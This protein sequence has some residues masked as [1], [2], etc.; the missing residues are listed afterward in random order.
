M[1][2]HRRKSMKMKPSRDKPCSSQKVR[3]RTNCAV[4]E[5]QS[6]PLS[7]KFIYMDV[8]HGKQADLMEEQLKKL[9]AKVE[10]F[11]SGEVNYVISASGPT[12]CKTS[13]RLNVWEEN[14]QSPSLTSPFNC[15]PSPSGCTDTKRVV[16][17]RGKA[18]AQI[19]CAK[20]QTSSVVANAEKLG[21]KVI[22]FDVATKWLEKELKKI[23]KEFKNEG[24]LKKVSERKPRCSKSEIKK[25]RKLLRD[26]YIKFEAVNKCHRPIK[27]EFP[28]LPKLNLLSPPGICPFG[29]AKLKVQHQYRP[30]KAAQENSHNARMDTVKTLD[31]NPTK[32]D[33]PRLMQSVSLVPELVGVPIVTAGDVKCNL[34]LRL[35]KLTQINKQQGYC[36]CCE[37]KYKDLEQHLISEEHRTFVRD[38]SNYE[39]LDALISKIPSTVEFLQTVLMKHC[40]QKQKDVGT[41]TMCSLL[42]IEPPISPLTTERTAIYTL[43]K[44]SPSHNSMPVTDAELVSQVE[45]TPVKGK[46][47]EKSLQAVVIRRPMPS[48]IFTSPRRKQPTPSKKPWVQE[49]S[50]VFRDSPM[51]SLQPSCSSSPSFL[52]TDSNVFSP[53]LLNVKF[54]P[55]KTVSRSLINIIDFNQKTTSDTT[56]TISQDEC[57]QA[58][59]ENN[60]SPSV[61]LAKEAKC[62]SNFKHNSADE[63]GKNELHDGTC[64]N[65]SMNCFEE[66]ESTNLGNNTLH[67]TQLEDHLSIPELISVN[68]EDDL[69]VGNNLKRQKCKKKMHIKRDKIRNKLK[70]EV[71]KSDIIVPCIADRVKNR[72]RNNSEVANIVQDD[73]HSATEIP[74]LISSPQAPLSSPNIKT[75]SEQLSNKMNT[76]Q[77]LVCK[78]TGNEIIM[79]TPFEM[80]TE[81]VT[82]QNKIDAKMVVVSSLKCRNNTETIE[83][84]QHRYKEE[85]S[86]PS[87]KKTETD[88]SCVT[89]HQLKIRIDTSDV[90]PVKKNIDSKI[91]AG[92]KHDSELSYTPKKIELTTE[93]VPSCKKNIFMAIQSCN[94][95]TACK[96]QTTNCSNVKSVEADEAPVKHQTALHNE[97]IDIGTDLSFPVM[98]IQEK[99]HTFNENT[100]P[101]QQEEKLSHLKE[102]VPFNQFVHNKNGSHC[103]YPSVT[104]C[105]LNI[106]SM[107]PKKC[108]YLEKLKK[109]HCVEVGLDSPNQLSNRQ[110][111]KKMEGAL[112][113]IV[114]PSKTSLKA[115]EVKHKEDKKSN[116]TICETE[117]C[118][119]KMFPVPNI[120]DC[121]KTRC[122]KQTTDIFKYNEENNKKTEN[123]KEEKHS[124][125]NFSRPDLEAK[126]KKNNIEKTEEETLTV[127]P[128]IAEC[129]KKRR[130]CTMFNHEGQYTLNSLF[131]ELSSSSKKSTKTKR[132]VNLS[133]SGNVNSEAEDS[134]I[135]CNRGSAVVIRRKN[136]KQLIDRRPVSRDW[137]IVEADSSEHSS[138]LVH[139]ENNVSSQQISTDIDR[140]ISAMSSENS[141]LKDNHAHAN[142]VEKTKVKICEGT[143]SSPGI[144]MKIKR[145]FNNMF[146]SFLED[147]NFSPTGAAV[148]RRKLEHIESKHETEIS[149]SSLNSI[150]LSLA[151]RAPSPRFSSPKENKFVKA[152]VENVPYVSLL[153]SPSPVFTMPQ[154]SNNPQ[155]TNKHNTS[156]NIFNNL[157]SAYDSRGEIDSSK[158][159]AMPLSK[160]PINNVG[161]IHTNTIVKC[162]SLSPER[163]HNS[164]LDSPY[165]NSSIQDTEEALE[166]SSTEHSDSSSVDLLTD[167]TSSSETSWDSSNH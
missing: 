5:K 88:K 84:T 42:T 98:S 51:A 17:S 74:Q 72:S 94:V 103:L 113:E 156:S 73:I 147:D 128:N 160:L 109:K 8:K 96:L 90:T 149:I 82:C 77:N 144:K 111:T 24:V 54:Q 133:S 132:G 87:H 97:R 32:L 53:Q 150:S 152:A 86:M 159:Q 127:V 110:L 162:R 11:L 83:T 92:L 56:E 25:R 142:S 78:N 23:E 158:M 117:L 105:H 29:E 124:S 14:P 37:L 112:K 131:R 68:T 61:K 99:I 101:S 165:S 10:K 104:M 9:G 46:N 27:A 161:Q 1:T 81:K 36:D 136:Q 135:S 91:L 151:N 75:C 21:I 62:I 67:K 164:Q 157:K 167:S 115:V 148:K 114:T 12:H 137:S 18:L 130:S 16:V 102:Q 146:S 79:T 49:R 95:E 126:S 48:G 39:S 155:P 116:K 59:L 140:P 38:K 69:T 129:V 143:S 125:L 33:E 22:S 47:N 58:K 119:V 45:N 3:K 2:S 65:N 43:E 107:K 31:S 30:R 121:V 13:E 106:S 166:I 71:V 26:N 40:V 70:A 154:H 7:N 50:M 4:M 145:H 134:E 93:F 108:S 19:A 66:N 118:T 44:A 163:I 15:G 63:I 20:N 60:T 6:L 123:Q 41:D 153:R 57:T 55:K 76:D 80:D 120:A 138:S 64:Q 85:K 28:R 139:N 34:N 122:R 52:A 141:I 35:K 100:L 89:Q